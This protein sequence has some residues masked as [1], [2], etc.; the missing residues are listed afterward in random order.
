VADSNNA[1]VVEL[2]QGSTT[3]TVLPL[4][5]L[6]DPEGVAVDSEGN[7]FVTDSE[8]NL[9]LELPR[10]AA[11]PIALPFVGLSRP[12]GVAVDPQGDVFVVDSG[13]ERALEFG[14]RR[15]DPDGDFFEWPRWSGLDRRGPGERC[16]RHQHDECRQS[17]EPERGGHRTR[18]RL[19]IAKSA[20]HRLWRQRAQSIRRWGVAADALGDVFM[21]EG[22]ACRRE[23][24]PITGSHIPQSLHQTQY[25]S[26]LRLDMT[27]TCTEVVRTPRSAGAWGPEGSGPNLHRGPDSSLVIPVTATHT[28]RNVHL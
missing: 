12:E 11:A 15:D 4:T 21:S 6:S 23:I 16:N 13:N 18:Q 25:G 14:E 10:D 5:G 20:A 24:R 19:D 2:T 3:Q 1:R 26:G 9:V 7:V 8:N 27:C 28:S 17:P 22:G